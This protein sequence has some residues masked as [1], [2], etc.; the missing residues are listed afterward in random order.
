[1]IDECKK[2]RTCLYCGAFNGTV[3]KKPSESL[4]IIHDKYVVGRDQEIDDLV[5]QFEHS[6]QVNPEIEK[7]L[8]DTQDDL[9]PLK[10]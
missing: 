4:K 6:C 8:K 9:D 1:M 3:K 10:V 7:S 2:M 5:K